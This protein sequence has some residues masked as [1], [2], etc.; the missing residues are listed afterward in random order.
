MRSSKKILIFTLN[1]SFKNDLGAAFTGGESDP[2][3][4]D[5]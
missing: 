3:R 2:R 5:S 1:T 4:K